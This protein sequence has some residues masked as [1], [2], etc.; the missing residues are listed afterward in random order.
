VTNSERYYNKESDDPCFLENIKR[1][2]SKLALGSRVYQYSIMEKLP[3]EKFDTQSV[4]LIV[5]YTFNGAEYKTVWS[6]KN[7][8]YLRIKK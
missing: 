2:Q 8:Q 6:H 4:W 1:L 7:N 5:Y 3:H